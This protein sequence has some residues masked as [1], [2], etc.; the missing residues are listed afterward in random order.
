MTF[1]DQLLNTISIILGFL[2]TGI[3]LN[4]FISTPI[5]SEVTQIMI[6]NAKKAF[7]SFNKNEKQ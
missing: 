4:I 1:V 6:Q 2:L 7:T 5:G 3:L